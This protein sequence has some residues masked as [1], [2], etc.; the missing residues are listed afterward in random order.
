MPWGPRKMSHA[1]SWPLFIFFTSY[2]YVNTHFVTPAIAVFC[3]QEKWGH[4]RVWSCPALEW[5]LYC[6]PLTWPCQS[7]RGWQHR[8]TG[9]HGGFRISALDISG[10]SNWRGK[11]A[12]WDFFW[13]CLYYLYDFYVSLDMF[14]GEGIMDISYFSSHHRSKTR[15]AME[16][17]D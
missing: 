9:A 3:Y 6:G 11:R 4:F 7:H 16:L 2:Q 17:Q 8:F 1:C 14:R 10:L 13:G 12:P 5:A 15:A